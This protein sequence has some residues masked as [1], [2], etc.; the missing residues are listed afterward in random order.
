MTLS[1]FAN[2][3][4]L[5][6]FNEAKFPRMFP[7]GAIF[8]KSYNKLRLA[9]IHNI[10]EIINANVS[11]GQFYLD[12]S[13]SDI[14][15]E[16]SYEIS[17]AWCNSTEKGV[18][19]FIGYH[20]VSTQNIVQTFSRTY[21]MPFISPGPI[22]E[23]VPYNNDFI[24]HMFPPYATAIADLIA[25]Y[26]WKRAYYLYEN[27]EALVR[28]EK[29]LKSLHERDKDAE[30]DALYVHDVHNA[31][32]HLRR[33]DEHSLF[34]EDERVQLARV[35]TA[36]ISGEKAIIIDV[37]SYDSIHVL[38][39]QIQQVGMNRVQY[40]YIIAGLDIDSV[41]I[42]GLRY[43]GVNV[44]GF[45]LV[46][47]E[48][49][50]VVE[51]LKDWSRTSWGAGTRKLDVN[52]ALLLDSVSV[53]QKA[54]LMIKNSPTLRNSFDKTF[55][56]GKVYSNDTQGVPCGERP[57]SPWQHGAMLIK[58]FKR[59]K[60][61]GLSGLVAFDKHGFRKQYTLDVMSLKGPEGMKKIGVWT[62][63]TGLNI[64]EVGLK[65]LISRGLMERELLYVTSLIEEPFLMERPLVKN[66][67]GENITLKGNDR[68]E[69][70]CKDLLDELSKLL[71]FDYEIRLV[72]DKSYGT[73]RNG[74]WDGMIGQLL[75]KTADMAVAPLTINAVRERVVEFTKPF[76]NL[77]ISIM[78]KKPEKQKPGVFSF[79]NP[80]SSMVWMYICAVCLVV[81]LFLF[82]IGRISP[83]QWTLKDEGGG[84]VASTEFSLT[85]CVWFS[86]GSLMQQGGDI[87]LRCVSSRTLASV[88]SLFTLI[89]VSTYTANLAAFLT[90]EKLLTPIRDVE[91]LAYHNTILYGTRG[92]GSTED[93]FKYSNIP[94]YKY[95]WQKM[96]ANR[97]SVI[98]KSTLEGVGKVRNS[99]S[100]YAFLLESTMN[101]YISQR[102]PCNTMMVGEQLDAKGYGI[103]TPF[104]SRWN[105]KLNWA[106]LKLRESAY[107]AALQKK[108][109]YDKSECF[110][111]K[112]SKQNP[113]AL[114]NVAGIFYVLIGGFFI[115]MIVSL[116]EF[117]YK[118]HKDARQ[119]KL[120]LGQALRFK[121]EMTI[122]GSPAEQPILLKQNGLQ[123]IPSVPVSR[124][125]TVSLV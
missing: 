122:R 110:H 116:A 119:K 121:A 115:A 26:R 36:R 16:N 31:Y 7:I 10:R 12:V 88:W 41:D 94:V 70:Y 13:R 66:S 107:L 25:G 74:T 56:R 14:D 93:F 86:L 50:E 3:A 49:F 99:K 17:T 60:F 76:M 43:S 40:H 123:R 81:G 120:S 1:L 84:F 38:L 42:D 30:I 124:P 61:S 15:I 102:K 34:S 28:L 95:M 71:N 82:L 5:C 87:T 51:F 69:G 24:I 54:L 64:T 59:V 11:G 27:T 79:M 75:N 73:L 113:L 101:S 53:F 37:E 23:K 105:R 52:I 118:A 109:W 111:N 85:N 21:Q 89:L 22:T 117:L 125:G 112:E 58:E 90:V 72:E 98:T 96:S 78:I 19:S 46:N 18:F 108:W 83:Y 55:R 80:F 65:N 4:Q 104:S 39:K 92:G 8:D 62:P 103:A 9:F 63:E 100:K 97:K 20:S 67:D 33:V 2:N 77:G 47:P 91:E 44:T 45:R 114:S 6:S 29:I 68:Y 32:S 48:S 35:N 106:V 57:V